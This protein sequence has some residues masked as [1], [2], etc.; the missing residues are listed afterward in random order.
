MSD[1]DLQ[2]LMVEIAPGVFRA[3]VW[4]TASKRWEL[5]AGVDARAALRAGVALP[6]E[7]GH[8]PESQSE[9]RER[10]DWEA[11]PVTVLRDF[12]RQAGLSG[13]TTLPKAALV[14]ALEES[15]W[16]PGD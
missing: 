14:S 3:R 1:D 15:G 7:P 6:A 13:V 4:H 16:R 2:A 9:A 12:G 5:M 8:A 11:H 10:Y